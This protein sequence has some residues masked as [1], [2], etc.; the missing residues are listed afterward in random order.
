MQYV[1]RLQILYDGDHIQ[2]SPFECAVFDIA[3]IQVYG[4]D[5][6]IVGQELKFI[7]DAESAGQGRV[8]VRRRRRRTLLSKL[9]RRFEGVR[10]A[11]RSNDSMLDY[12]DWSRAL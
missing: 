9:D 7:V 8:E 10:D 4:L 3:Q 1:L 5:V 12:R 2:G 6:G 11:R